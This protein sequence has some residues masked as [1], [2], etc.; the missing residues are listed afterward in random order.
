MHAKRGIR[1]AQVINDR[2]AEYQHDAVNH[3]QKKAERGEHLDFLDILLSSSTM[4]GAAL[5]M[6][7]IIA[8][9]G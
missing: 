2:L 8:Q 6:D 3:L 1:C 7:D 4:E 5:S 9:V